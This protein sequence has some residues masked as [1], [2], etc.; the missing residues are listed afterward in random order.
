MHDLLRD[1][2]AESVQREPVA[3]ER[4]AAVGR[5]LD[6]YLATAAEAA[7]K[8]GDALG[9]AEARAAGAYFAAELGQ[10]DLAATMAE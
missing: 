4:N 5:R 2:A 6:Y 3:S 9:L 10:H 7:E 8:V 1:D